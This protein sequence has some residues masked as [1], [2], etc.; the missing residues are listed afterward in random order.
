M[1]DRKQGPLVNPEF[2]DE[3]EPIPTPV[4]ATTA[5]PPRSFEEIDYE[6]ARE[7]YNE[8]ARRANQEAYWIHREARRGQR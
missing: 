7:R 8:L 5:P 4:E 1:L 6:L 3:P 2:W